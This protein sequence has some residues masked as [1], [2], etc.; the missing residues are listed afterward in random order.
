MFC[1]D[2]RLK[3]G[4][5]LLLANRT[6]KKGHILGFKFHKDLR[7]LQVQAIQQRKLALLIPVVL[8]ASIYPP[9]FRLYQ[10]AP[11]RATILFM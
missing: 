3:Y 4:K 7:I 1:N 2:N 10:L 9:K 11:G 5:A 6:L 8:Q